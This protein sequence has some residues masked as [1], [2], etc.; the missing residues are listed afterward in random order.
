M[1]LINA[2]KAIEMLEGVVEKFGPNIRYG[3]VFESVTGREYRENDTCRNLHVK[4]DGSFVPL[5]IVGQAFA[6][7]YTENNAPGLEHGSVYTLTGNL[8]RDSVVDITILAADVL[9]AAQR[10]QDGGGT[11]GEALHEARQARD[12]QY[13]NDTISR[14]ASR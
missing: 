1:E 11:W 6:P 5:C 8:Y 4:D 10:M 13:E 12:N 7:Y 3:D 9:S 2:A 14:F